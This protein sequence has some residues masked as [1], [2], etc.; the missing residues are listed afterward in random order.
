MGACSG[1][2]VS[3]P[4]PLGNKET[5]SPGAAVCE[6]GRERLDTGDVWTSAPPSCF[7]LSAPSSSYP[8]DSCFKKKKKKATI[9][10]Q[11]MLALSGA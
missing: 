9:S 7:V 10:S 1:K 3:T 4:R 11:W 5:S 2:I 8:S 6:P